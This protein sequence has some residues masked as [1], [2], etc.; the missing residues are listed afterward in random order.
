MNILITPNLADKKCNFAINNGQ[1]FSAYPKRGLQYQNLMPLAKDTVSF[2]GKTDE[3]TRLLENAIKTLYDSFEPKTQIVATK[4][5]KSLETVCSKMSE[6][7]FSYDPIY[8]AKHPIKTKKS[9]YDKLG[10]QGSVKDLV[11]GTVYWKN[12]QDV[13]AFGKFI[14]E[15]K[16]EGWKVATFR[17]IDSD[18]KKMTTF[19]DVEIRQDGIVKEDLHVLP[20]L[21]QRSEIS[22][23]RR[24]TYSDWQVLF[25]NG[26]MASEV[27]FLYGPKYAEAKE[28]ESQFVYNIIRCFKENFHI[29][30]NASFKDY[31]PGKRIASNV[32]L[33]SNR[34]IE[35]IS[36]PL[37]TNGKNADLGIKGEQKLKPSIS[38]IHCS[39]IDG[40]MNGIRQKISKYYSALKKEIKT[41]EYIIN[42]IKN[43]YEY[44]LRENKTISPEEIKIVRQKLKN[45]LPVYEAEDIGSAVTA[46]EFLKKTI[47][48]YGEK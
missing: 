40:L 20:P 15:M 34:L 39:E 25:T 28:A 33:I 19:P 42:Y 35:D 32:N 26:D 24:S 2:T 31:T 9:F 47:A 36:R 17:K 43:S 3:S 6:M 10:R 1:I 8:N 46:H 11:R 12:Q 41:D 18:T 13:E 23:P 27:I 7:G 5:H 16:E 22:R 29:D 48:K 4:L 44:S 21:L 14:E 45:L 30:L 38:K 37:F